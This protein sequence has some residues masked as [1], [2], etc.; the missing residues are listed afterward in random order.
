MDYYNPATNTERR[1]CPQGRTSCG[2][3]PPL[4]APHHDEATQSRPPTTPTPPRSS[5]PSSS[6]RQLPPRSACCSFLRA[7]P[8]PAPA[9]DDYDARTTTGA[10]TASPTP[11]LLDPPWAW[12]T[13]ASRRT[14]ATRTWL[15]AAAAHSLPRMCFLLACARGARQATASS[16]GTAAGRR[17]AAPRLRSAIRRRAR[18]E[19]LCER[20]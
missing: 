10:F 14:W 8:A 6:S 1:A 15:A 20:E 4:R 12:S 18:R 16:D 17:G 19:A 11:S 2:D 5:P 3:A 13:E 7:A 9:Y